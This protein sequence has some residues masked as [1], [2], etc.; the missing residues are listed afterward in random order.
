MLNYITVT[1]NL[2]IFQ[3][4]GNIHGPYKAY[5]LRPVKSGANEFDYQSV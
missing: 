5:R 3:S 1:Q 4:V 2:S